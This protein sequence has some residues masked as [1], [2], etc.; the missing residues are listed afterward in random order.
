MRTDQL[1]DQLVHDLRPSPPLRP[2]WLRASRWLLGATAYLGLLALAL[3]SSADVA[4]NGTGWRFV[5]PQVAALAMAASAAVAAFASTVPGASG[6]PLMATA[7]AAVL[8]IATLS[9][10]AVEEL[11]STGG[12]GLLA[13]GEWS[14]VALAVI[15][16]ALPAL[17]MAAM[18]RRGALLSPVLTTALGAVSITSLANIAACVSH[19]HP[20]SAVI[21]VWHG[22]FIVALAAL[23]ALASRRAQV[24]S[25][26]MTP[27][28]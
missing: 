20:S 18:L 26:K 9:G 2:A 25:W 19:P 16:G 14:C 17:G 10:G 22:G 7:G 15:G 3:T 4:A 8:W 1:I 12:A 21:L 28:V 23:A 24:A 27:T 11:R 13:P 6:R 5:A